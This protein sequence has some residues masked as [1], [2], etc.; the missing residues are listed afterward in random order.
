MLLELA[1]QPAP[2][3]LNL[4]ETIVA[5]KAI[6]RVDDSGP[7]PVVRITGTD[8]RTRDV[9][10]HLIESVDIPGRSAL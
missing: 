1:R 10:L 3:L 6:E 2:C 7:M 4:P 9:P 5:A 8:G